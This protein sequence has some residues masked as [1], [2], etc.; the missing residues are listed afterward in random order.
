M[1]RYCSTRTFPAATAAR[2]TKRVVG[3]VLGVLVSACTLMAAVA[4]SSVAI[5]GGQPD[6]DGHPHV[7]GTVLYYAPRNETIVNC[8][9]SLIS[10]TVFV[11]AAHCGRDGTRRAVAFDEVFDAETSPRYEGTFHAHPNYDP[12]QQ[13]KNDVAVIVLDQPVAGV[14]PSELPELPEAGLLERMKADGSLTQSSRFT[15]V[16]YGMLGFTMDAGGPTPV[17]GQ[18]RHNSVG[19]FDALSPAQ[20]H[21]SQNSA[22]GDGGTCNG[23]SGGPNFLGAGEEETKIIAGIT[24]TGDTYCKATNVAYRLDSQAARDFLGRYVVLP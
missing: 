12:A 18:S 2:R 19:S 3:R 11:T 23:D 4:S 21:L 5:T 14:D 1:T 13:Y 22:L 9:G 6:E 10:P 20:L 8:T 16:G 17:R 24:S 15:S 7:G